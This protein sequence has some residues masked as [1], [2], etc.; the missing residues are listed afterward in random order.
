MGRAMEAPPKTASVAAQ[1]K[2]TWQDDDWMRA[3]A[4]RDAQRL[5]M[6]IYEVHLPSWRRRDDGEPLNYVELAEALCGHA[7]RFG[8]THLE[9]MPVSE[10][11]YSPSWGYQVSGYYAPT[12]R[13]GAPDD[14]RRFIDICHAHSIGVLLDWVPA[15]FPKDA[16]ALAR[17]DGTALYED[18]DPKRGEHPDWGT[19]IFNYGR[20]EVRNFLLANAVYWLKEF[21]F[22]GLRVDAVASMLYLDYSRQEGQWTPNMHGGREN[23]DAVS[24]LKEMN[25]WVQAECP[26]A[27]TIAEESTAW[28]GVTAPLDQGGLGFTFKWNMGWMHD[29]LKYFREDPIHRKHHHDALTFA[30][31]YENS[32]R[33]INALSHD[34]VVHGKGS[35]F[36]KMQGDDW[37]KFANLRILLIY[38]ATRPG[39]VLNF[40]GAELADPNEWRDDGQV[41]WELA[42]QPARMSHATF[43]EALG[44]LYK[45]EESL[46]RKDPDPEGFEWIDCEDRDH[47]VLA[48]LRVGATS[49]SVVILNLTPISRPGY[50]VGVPSPGTYKTLL[51]TDDAAYGGSGNFPPQD[52]PSEEMAWQGRRHSVVV[53]LPPLAALVLKVPEA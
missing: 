40:M 15:H 11:P 8:Y 53:D 46:W 49:Q 35:L 34:E 19:Y 31:V 30:M 13:L 18:P 26:G 42:A 4:T 39:K 6:N 32:E 14:L 29:T 50:R 2:Y 51:S 47:S 44:D 22:D 41:P 21:H 28:P 24:F 27:C 38:Q 37:Q 7:N 3:R 43:L 25:A 36:Q 45:G 9:L 5:P 16:F 12:A 17:F 33:F 52:A 20:N 1:T 23:L 48:Y 10:H